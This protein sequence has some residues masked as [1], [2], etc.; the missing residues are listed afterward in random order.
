MYKFSFQKLFKNSIGSRYLTLDEKVA[1]VRVNFK[2][3][4]QGMCEVKEERA[5]AIQD[6]MDLWL[7][8]RN[9]VVYVCTSIATDHS[10]LGDDFTLEFTLMKAL[11]DTYYHMRLSKGGSDLPYISS[12]TSEKL[13]KI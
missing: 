7:D 2:I 6:L 9:Q 12:L 11:D 3:P 5:N 13:K 4:P 8:Y 10:E 1:F